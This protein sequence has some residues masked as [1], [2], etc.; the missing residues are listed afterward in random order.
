MPGTVAHTPYWQLDQR[1]DGV[2]LW[3]EKHGVRIPATRIARYRKS[4]DELLQIYESGDEGSAWD[5]FPELVNTLFE[6]HELLL[7]HEGLA[8]HTGEVDLRSKLSEIAKG[9]TSYTEE[10]GRSSNRARNTAFELILA[11]RL[12]SVGLHMDQALP[13]DTACRCNNRTLLFECKR[14]ME[15]AN[16]ER[17]VKKV[18]KQ[19]KRQYQNPKRVRARGIIAVDVSRLSNPD[20]KILVANSEED[21]GKILETLLGRFID[22]NVDVWRKAKENKTIGILLRVAMMAITGGGSGSL[23]YCQQYSLTPFYDAGTNYCTALELGNR[24]AAG[25]SNHC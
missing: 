13:T 7:I 16:L 15:K 9:P 4:F 21:A 1:L 23:T 25:L 8:N 18:D 2:I 12:S 10:D 17:N 6:V 24:L 14:P 3:L 5:N 20:S 22:D 11:S 19:L